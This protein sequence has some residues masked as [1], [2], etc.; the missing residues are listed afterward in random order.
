[1]LSKLGE[2]CLFHDLNLYFLPVITQARTPPE[3]L[4]NTRLRLSSDLLN[5]VGVCE[6]HRLKKVLCRRPLQA[7]GDNRT[8]VKV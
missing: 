5:Q 7:T 3:L 6:L 4:C 1:M 2:Q 8:T